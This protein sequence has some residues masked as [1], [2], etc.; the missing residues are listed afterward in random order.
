MGEAEF[1]DF[2]GNGKVGPS[3]QAKCPSVLNPTLRQLAR[4][5]FFK[6]F[7]FT[8]AA[9]VDWFDVIAATQGKSMNIDPINQWI[10]IG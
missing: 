1:T 3:M 6:I 4:A 10:A 9:E 2:E 5:M 7:K 8:S